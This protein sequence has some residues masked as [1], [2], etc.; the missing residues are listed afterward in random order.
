MMVGTVDDDGILDD[1]ASS[2][3]GFRIEGVRY[4]RPI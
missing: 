1:A 4:V 2:G 3:H